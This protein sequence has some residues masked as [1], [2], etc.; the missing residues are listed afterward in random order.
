MGDLYEFNGAHV[1]IRQRDLRR[2]YRIQNLRRRLK[3]AEDALLS[4]LMDRALRGAHIE[5]GDHALEL[6]K[7]PGSVRM[8]VDGKAVGE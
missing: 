8:L 5:P 3:S 6:K 7:G 4:D 2:L 1:P